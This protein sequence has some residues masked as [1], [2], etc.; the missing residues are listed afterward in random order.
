MEIEFFEAERVTQA[1]FRLMVV[2]ELFVLIVDCDQGTRSV[3]NDAENV[4]HRVSAYLGGLDRRKLF[5]RDSMGRFDILL[6][7]IHDNFVGF[8][9]CTP[10]QNEFLSRL[11]VPF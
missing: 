1:Q 3:T 10:A 6:T 2:N 8:K 4:V 9:T 5:Y 11:C 7:D